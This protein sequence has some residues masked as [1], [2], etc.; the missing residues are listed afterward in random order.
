ME[1]KNF[2]NYLI[3]PDGKLYNKKK[4]IFHKPSRNSYTILNDQKKRFGLSIRFL[5]EDYYPDMYPKTHN[6]KGE[7]KKKR[8]IFQNPRNQENKK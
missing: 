8:F 1:I 5:L 6:R 2:S 4:K 7:G 3:Y